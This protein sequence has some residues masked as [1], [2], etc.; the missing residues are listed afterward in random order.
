MAQQLLVFIAFIESLDSAASTHI[1]WLIAT[2]NF[3]ADIIFW[4]LWAPAHM[5]CLYI[6]AG[7]HTYT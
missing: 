2:C 5:E 3:N 6:H 4:P 1:E 7:T